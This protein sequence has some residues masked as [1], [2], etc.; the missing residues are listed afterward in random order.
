MAMEMLYVIIF[1]W[2]VVAFVNFYKHFLTVLIALEFIVLVLF[3]FFFYYLNFY[4]LEYYYCL[5][6][7]VFSVCEGVLG[8][9]ILVKLFRSN[10]N[11]HFLGFSM[12]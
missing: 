9:A 7:L 6:Y 11:D 3:L 10:K 4:N 2:G 1:F 5:Y 12:L 8:L